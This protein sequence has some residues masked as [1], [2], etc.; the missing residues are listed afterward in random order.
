M[1]ADQITEDNSPKAL[2]FLRQ[3]LILSVQYPFKL[4]LKQFGF[5]IVVHPM[6]TSLSSDLPITPQAPSFNPQSRHIKPK[7][8]PTH[9]H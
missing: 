7:S 6:L 4:S 1:I 2:S 3:R 5:F 9:S 8:E